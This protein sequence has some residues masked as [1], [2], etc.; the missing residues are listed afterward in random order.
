MASKERYDVRIRLEEQLRDAF[1]HISIEDVSDDSLLSTLET[2]SVLVGGISNALAVARKT[3]KTR[4][5]VGVLGAGFKGIMSEKTQ[6]SAELDIHWVKSAW[7]WILIILSK[8]FLN[9]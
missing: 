4:K 5:V 7:N 8:M 9:R 2:V 6:Y 1:P 3:S